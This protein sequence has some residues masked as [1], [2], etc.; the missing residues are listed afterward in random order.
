M[1]VSRREFVAVIILLSIAVT[2]FLYPLTQAVP[3]PSP[4]LGLDDFPSTF[5]YVIKTDGLG[6]Y[7]M[8]DST[9][10]EAF[11]SDNQTL[12][13]QFALGNLTSG[14][15]YLMQVQHNSSLTIPANVLV[16]E[17]YQG[18]LTYRTASMAQHIPASSTDNITGSYIYLGSLP[19]DP[20]SLVVGEMW[21]NSVSEQ[22]KC[23][24][25]SVIV[26]SSGAT[27]P[28]GPAGTA[29][30][31]PYSYLI[32]NNATATY[33][34]NGTTGQ[35]DYQSTNASN[36]INFA[37]SNTTFGT[38]VL[39]SGSHSISSAIIPKSNVTLSLMAGAIL[40]RVVASTGYMFDADSI[41]DFHLIGQPH[42]MIDCNSLYG[43]DFD[44][45]T[46]CSI[47]NLEIK[48]SLS[49]A[50]YLKRSND[51]VLRNLY[52]HAWDK[53]AA[54]SHC[55]EIDGSSRN[56][57]DHLIVDGIDANAA[58]RVCVWV[59]NNYYA[60]ME[61]G[62]N[63]ILGGWYKNSPTDN[64]IYISGVY[65]QTIIGTTISGCHASDHGGLKLRPSIK[66]QVSDLR[67][68]DCWGGIEV[69]TS[70][71]RFD[72][73]EFNYVQAIITD[74][75]GYGVNVV[76]DAANENVTGNVFD[77]IITNVTAG[78]GLNFGT[79]Y[80]N[81]FLTGNTFQLTESLINKAGVSMS[82]S[83]TS[84]SVSYNTITGY[85]NRTGTA[86]FSG[87]IRINNANCTNNYFHVF[88]NYDLGGDY[89]VDS[90]TN[91]MWD[92]NCIFNLKPIRLV[93]YS[94]N[95]TATTCV[96]THGLFS[97]P[98]T[99]IASGNDTALHYATTAISSTQITFTISG[100]P[101]GNWT[102]YYFAR[103]EP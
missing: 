66:A 75:V 27:G 48:N 102:V 54:S 72:N 78:H 13:E 73:S 21:Y 47:E 29:N 59:G 3:K 77:L 86:G 89:V 92:D 98:Q 28:A 7:W 51:S 22:F 70:G 65:N 90:G 10:H 17:D 91:T 62:D 35:V 93:S 18:V 52:V 41:S 55:I 37:I 68:M 20:V 94:I 61:S 76:T 87:G 85:F 46:F 74:S 1:N 31:L 24:N 43:F 44:Q 14:T 60:T 82:C 23:Y 16:I 4:N 5:S 81:C 9:G 8:T 80:T 49:G 25:G 42:V 40:T 19:S 12:V 57:L 84:S 56:V 63:K 32:F 83:E 101:G 2:I 53:A 100:T 64:G 88:S 45:V 95:T 11:W 99:V 79:S 103:Y 50:I 38:V 97:T 30:G 26:L 58:A 96:I 34:V 36:M 39:Q 15:I 69:S 67:I 6:V 71:A 33:M